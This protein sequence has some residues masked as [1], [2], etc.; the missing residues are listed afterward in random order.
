M[1][2]KIV[3]IATYGFKSTG[4][5]YNFLRDILDLKELVRKNNISVST[6]KSYIDW[7][8]GLNNYWKQYYKSSLNYFTRVK[9][10]YSVHPTVS[11]FE[12]KTNQAI[13]DGKD[14][15]INWVLIG[16]LTGSVVL[17]LVG[18]IIILIIKKRKIKKEQIETVINIPFST[19]QFNKTVVDNQPPIQ[20]Q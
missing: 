17:V 20:Q 16:G 4:G 18:V 15:E 1:D 13:K 2:G 19:P 14:K 12:I 7:N 11:E 5:N 9:S 3:G 6:S 10:N 8:L